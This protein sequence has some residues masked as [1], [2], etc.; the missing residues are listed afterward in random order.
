MDDVTQVATGLNQLLTYGPM[1]ILLAYFMVKDWFR[2][3][4]SDDIIEKNTEVIKEFT[5]A[6]NVLTSQGAK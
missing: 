6:L 2:G 3:K 5:V 1:G 4:K